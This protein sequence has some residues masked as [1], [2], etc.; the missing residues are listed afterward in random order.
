MQNKLLSGHVS[1]VDLRK[2]L[3]NGATVFRTDVSAKDLPIV[4]QLYNSALRDV[5]IAAVVMS[6]LAFLATFGME[7]NRNLLRKESAGGTAPERLAEGIKKVE[8]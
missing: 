3:S 7:W 4:L 5:F 1:G 2:V 8:Q 6:A